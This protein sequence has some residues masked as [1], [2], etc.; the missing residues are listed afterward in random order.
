LP[1]DRSPSPRPHQPSRKANTFSQNPVFC[2]FAKK[3]PEFAPGPFF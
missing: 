2:V 1:A 3:A